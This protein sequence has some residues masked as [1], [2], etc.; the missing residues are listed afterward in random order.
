MGNKIKVS[1]ASFLAF[2]IISSILSPLG[3]VT[4]ALVDEFGIS[5]TYA[6]ALFSYV[7]TGL[8]VGSFLILFLNPILGVKKVVLIAGFILIL[9]LMSLGFIS[10]AFW[11]PIVFF[12]MGLACG[13][14]LSNAA[15]T[16]TSTYSERRRPSALLATDSFY[17]AAGFIVTPIAGIVVAQGMH[18]SIIYS[19]AAAA[20]LLMV[21]IVL[22]S[23]YPSEVNVGD[24]APVVSDK[25]KWPLGTYFIGI[26]IAI[27][28][29]C[30]VFIYSW[31]PAY[32]EQSFEATEAQSGFIVSRF[33][34]GLLLGQI[35]TFVLSF[36][37]KVSWVI[38][39][40]ATAATLISTGIWA[41]DTIASMGLS[42]LLLGF[43]MGGLLKPLLAF[44]TLFL[45]KPTS[46]LVG[47]YMLCMA[48]GS[49]ISPALSAFVVEMT[50]IKIVLTLVT[51]GFG[52]TTALI[53]ISLFLM[54]KNSRQ[55][56]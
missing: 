2:F 17:S 23:H 29:T 55:P 6:T 8:L 36:R 45:A 16:L 12:V 10:S 37:V 15:I 53:Y 49:A 32:A 28:L 27:Y 3:V 25:T 9:A 47:F 44:G 24:D 18:W 22:F 43:S 34:L 56:S 4:G 50:S 11:L 31:G 38:F 20:S 42:M 35:L 52:L 26:A 7:T 30:F 48:V 19:M 54:N 41:S 46:R 13:C 39:V 51:V 14:L 1:L 33:F 5:L 40:T 21:L